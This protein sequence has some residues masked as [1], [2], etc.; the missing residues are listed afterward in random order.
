MAHTIKV[1]CP[2]CKSDDCNATYEE[3]GELIRL[4]VAKATV[5]CNS[6]TYTKVGLLVNRKELVVETQEAESDE[7]EI[8]YM[9]LGRTPG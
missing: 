5:F 7:T 1:E 9:Y 8:E 3:L 2:R 6:C 4:S